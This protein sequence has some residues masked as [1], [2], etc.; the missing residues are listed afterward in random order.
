MTARKSRPKA[1][2]EHPDHW[3]VEPRDCIESLADHMAPLLRTGLFGHSKMMIVDPC[4]GGGNILDVF[5]DRGH[6]VEG[7]DIRDRGALNFLGIQD[8]LTLSR[9]PSLEPFGID[10]AFSIVMNPPY[11]A[12][13]SFIRHALTVANHYVA[14]L[15]PLSFLG[16]EGRLPFWA[17]HP[18]LTIA[19]L[20][21]RPTMPPG[22]KVQALGASAFKN[23]RILYCWIIWDVRKPRAK[24][25]S[26]W[27]PPFKGTA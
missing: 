11:K 9:W 10:P 21:K 8:F 16:S 23:G 18:P 5:R 22:D 17:E 14:A 6:R 3:Y 15:L 26:V 24:T 7:M 4:C 27:L 12:A 1:E 25:R 19:Y 20:A 2:T 13:E